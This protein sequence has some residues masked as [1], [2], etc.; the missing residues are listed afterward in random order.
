M[1]AP[2]SARK[3]RGCSEPNQ[4]LKEAKVGS[5][6]GFVKVAGKIIAI[7]HKTGASSGA[8][9]PRARFTGCSEHQ[10]S[11]REAPHCFASMEGK[12]LMPYSPNSLRSRLV[13]DDVAI[14]YKNASTIEHRTQDVCEKRRFV[15]THQNEFTGREEDLRSNARVIAHHAAFDRLLKQK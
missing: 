14:P 15:T 2:L 9:T 10:A 11:Y 5:S 8:A 13:V 1:T 6:R 12:P 7:P 3:T 4:F